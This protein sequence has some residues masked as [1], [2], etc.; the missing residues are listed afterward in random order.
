MVEARGK[1]HICPFCG[2][3]FYDMNRPDIVCPKCGKRLGRD[4]ELEFI[5]K[6]KK[7]E[8]KEKDDPAATD[9]DTGEEGPDA[10]GE[11]AF[12]DMDDD[13]GVKGARYDEEDY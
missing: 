5:K 3:M 6:K 2:A 7:A 10:E 13:D 12:F 1:K 9:F 4:D 8:V 11:A